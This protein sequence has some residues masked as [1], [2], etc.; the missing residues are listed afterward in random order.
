MTLDELAASYDWREVFG[1]GNGGNTDKVLDACPPGAEVDLTPPTIADV[2]EVVASAD[3][4]NDEAEWV[5]VFRLKDGR[6]LVAS[7]WCDYTGWDCAAGNHLEVAATLADAIA[8][9]L[10]DS[11]RARLGLASA[12]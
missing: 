11:Q 7:G 8:F 1:E 6:F 2:A 9:G 4:E 3:G 12:A 10:G 5:G